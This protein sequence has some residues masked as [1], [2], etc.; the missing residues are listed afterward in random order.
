MRAEAVGRNCHSGRRLVAVARLADASVNLNV[1]PWVNVPDY[2]AAVSEINQAILET[3]RAR[4]VV[5][6]L[7]RLEVRMLENAG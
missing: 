2:V 5:M 6:A 4:K 3:F 7:P 1:N